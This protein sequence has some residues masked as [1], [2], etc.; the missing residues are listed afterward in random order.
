MQQ[1]H[2][3]V[4]GSKLRKQRFLARLQL[5]HLGLE[6]RPREAVFDRVDNLPDAGAN[7]LELALGG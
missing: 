5:V 1:R 7:A 2:R 3:S 4:R 6:F